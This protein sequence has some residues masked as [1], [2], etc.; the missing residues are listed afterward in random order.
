[1]A[2]SALRRHRLR[3]LLPEERQEELVAAGLGL[4]QHAVLDLKLSGDGNTVYAATFGRSVWSLP[5]P[6]LIL[7]DQSAKPEPS[8]PSSGAPVPPRSIPAAC[9]VVALSRFRARTSVTSSILSPGSTPSAAL[10]AGQA[11]RGAR[12]E[13]W[14]DHEQAQ[15]CS[16]G[17][18]GQLKRGQVGTV[19]ARL[20]GIKQHG[21]DRR[22]RGSGAPP[23][24]GQGGEL[25]VAV[26]NRIPGLCTRLLRVHH[27][28]PRC[29]GKR[30]GGRVCGGA[31]DAHP[32]GGVFDHRR[33]VLT[34]PGQG[35]R[36]DKVDGRQGVGPGRGGGRPRCWWI[37]VVRDR[38]LRR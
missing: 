24:V 29:L 8:S 37:G 15:W 5:T 26:R 17:R 20:I 32:W 6:Q 33:D 19:R 25:R 18:S 4:A 16:Y 9:R 34:L 2:P 28:V 27:Q 22:S 31:Q 12:D 14:C 7:A 11:T 36:V 35:D 30:V 1:M 3:C 23:P 10:R 13:A 38:G 21:P